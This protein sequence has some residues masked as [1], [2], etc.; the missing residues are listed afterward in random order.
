MKPTV[1]KQTEAYLKQ[2]EAS[3]KRNENI[4]PYH[5]NP[6]IIDQLIIENDLQIARL[7][8]YPQIDLMPR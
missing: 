2:L 6:D 1:D 5:N 7:S 4:E 3:E 8:F